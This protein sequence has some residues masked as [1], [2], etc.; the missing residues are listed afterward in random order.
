MARKTAFIPQRPERPIVIG[1]G[2][3]ERCYFRHLSS[4]YR[5]SI[6]IEPKFFN[7]DDARHLE[8][9]INEVREK[10][11]QT[12]T[13]IV[14]YDRDV[15]AWNETERSRLDRLRHKYDK[16][17]SRVM[18]CDSMPSIEYWFLLHYEDT[19]AA[20]GTSGKVIERL[21][22]HIPQFQKKEKWLEQQS[23]VDDLCADG[24]LRTAT[25]RAKRHGTDGQSYSNMW[26]AI[27]YL[28][29]Q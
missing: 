11:S 25:E 15:T 19:A 8:K 28:G 7:G 1:P 9:Q 23:W 5:L 17:N 3:T 26:K 6:N 27:E 12:A 24:R 22:P 16:S 10:I 29:L 18:L 2:A 4:I 21:K 14:A 20:F 13:I